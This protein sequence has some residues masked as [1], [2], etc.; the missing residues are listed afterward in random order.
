MKISKKESHLNF[1]SCDFYFLIWN[2]PQSVDAWSP[3]LAVASP[4]SLP[5]TTTPD[6]ATNV[7]NAVTGNRD[8]S[9]YLRLHAALQSYPLGRASAHASASA[10]A[11]TR[12]RDT[13]RSG[14]VGHDADRGEF[15]EVPHLPLA[16][17]VAALH[18]SAVRISH[19]T[20]CK[21][22]CFLLC[23]VEP[24]FRYDPRVTKF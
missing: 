16:L 10:N 19:M 6:A 11:N 15:L 7:D 14:Q 20:F 17:T 3:M 2:A 22:F 12:G 21:R 9:V 24:L 1:F 5:T 4:S 13:V 8:A 18:P 23:H